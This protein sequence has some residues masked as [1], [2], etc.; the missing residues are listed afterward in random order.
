MSIVLG[1]L[2]IYILFLLAFITFACVVS[3][4]VYE[5]ANKPG[6]AALVPVYNVIILLEIIGYKWYYIFVFLAGSI[7][8]VGALVVLLFSISYNIKLAKAFGQSTGFGVCMFFFTPICMAI[9]AFDKNMN[10]IGPQ[11]NGDIDFNNLF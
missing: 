3:W 2:G 5:K 11:V 8:V 4:K 6:W 10:Y 9:I 1:V 7:P